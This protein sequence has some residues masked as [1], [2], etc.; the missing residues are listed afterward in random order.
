MRTRHS[1]GVLGVV[2][3][4]AFAG[5]AGPAGGILDGDEPEPSGAAG[6]DGGDSAF[7]GADDD[8]DDASGGDRQMTTEDEVGTVDQ[9]APLTDRALIHTGEIDLLVEDVPETSAEI[10][11]ITVD[12]GGFVSA[13]NQE[14][15]EAHNETWRT[16]T[17]VIRVP[18]DT[19]DA[20]M[21][22]LEAFGE[23]EGLETKT[24]DVTDELVDLEARLKNLRAERDRLRELYEDANETEDVLAVQ[25]ELSGVQEDIERLSARQQ[26]LEEDVA[27]ST[28]TIHL[29]EEK[30]EPEPHPEDPEWYETSVIAAF[31]ESVSGVAVTLRAIVVGIAFVAPYALV[32]GTP[33]VGAIAV[34]WYKAG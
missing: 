23:V 14:V 11:E 27:F 10:R 16:E 22:D 13:S 18:S 25:R 33:V 28:I 9:R 1:V 24:E 12:Q 31:L 26:A 30:P 7:S 17:I 32:F 15:H 3:L 20:T 21:S 4:I 29:A 6:G 34:Y 8:V 5:C 19:F 2:L